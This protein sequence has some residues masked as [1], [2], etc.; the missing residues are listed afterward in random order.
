MGDP[1]S[2]PANCVDSSTLICESSSVIFAGMLKPFFHP[3]IRLS[4]NAPPDAVAVRSLACSLNH[5]ELK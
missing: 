5:Q 3:F 2:T 1:A 4:D